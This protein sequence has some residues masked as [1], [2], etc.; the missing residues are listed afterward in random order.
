VITD[1]PYAIS[2]ATAPSVLEIRRQ[3]TSK[4]RP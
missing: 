2:P 1:D 3:E 4:G